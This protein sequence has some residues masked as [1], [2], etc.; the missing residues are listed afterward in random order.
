MNSNFGLVVAIFIC[1]TFVLGAQSDD[2]IVV[3]GTKTQ[4]EISETVE[5]VEVVDQEEISQMGART[6]EE[7]LQNISGVNINSHPQATV[8]MQGLEGAYVKVLVDGVEIAGDF[9]GATPISQIAVSDVERIEIVRG[10]SSALYGSDAMGGV[11]NVITKRGSEEKFSFDTV[12]EYSSIFRYFGSA[13]LG[14]SQDA[15]YSDLSTSWDYDDGHKIPREGFRGPYVQLLVPENLLGQVRGNLG[16]KKNGSDFNFHGIWVYNESEYALTRTNGLADK[17]HRLDFGLDGTYSIDDRSQLSGYATWKWAK[18]ETTQINYN[19]DSRSTKT[20]QFQDSEAEIRYLNDLNLSHQ[21]LIGTNAKWESLGG[22]SFEGNTKHAVQLAMYAQDSWTLDDEERL[23]LVPGLRFD[24]S[25]PL[26]DEAKLVYQF[27][28]KLSARWDVTDDVV[29]RTSYGMGFKVPTLKQKHWRFFHPAPYNFMLLGNPNLQA[30]TSHGVN[31]SIELKPAKWFNVTANGYFNYIK[32]LITSEV[33]DEN[34]GSWE[35]RAYINVREY[36]NKNK[37]ITSG[38]DVKANLQFGGFTA[39]FGYSFIYA[40]GT[41]DSES[42]FA[43]LTGRSPH[44]LNLKLGYTLENFGTT[45][46]GY[47]RWSA[48]EIYDADEGYKTPDLLEVDLRIEQPF[49][50]EKLFLYFGVENVL[51]NLHFILGSENQTQKDYF[52][53]HDGIIFTGGARYEY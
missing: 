14:Y 48:P 6:V 1:T 8:M 38:T 19:Y 28:P 47:A 33:T 43:P 24:M 23:R 27:T 39:T 37:A 40:I 12:Q 20:D 13:R 30:E 44:Q 11:I 3:S 29:L 42:Y 51:N 34:P 10:A 45:F 49:L 25:L 35:G 36:V 21:L 16:W 2:R 46:A 22:E 50:E 53:L 5:A 18:Q 41:E 31:A 52:G 7:V 4:Q 17:D 32:N 26:S 15:F 9:R